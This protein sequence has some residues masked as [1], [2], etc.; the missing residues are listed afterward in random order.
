MSNKDNEYKGSTFWQLILVI[1]G[2]ILAFTLLISLIAKMAGGAAPEA[3]APAAAVAAIEENIKPVAAVEVA[4]ADA[5]PHV[6][7]SGE[8][9]V[10]AVCGMCHGTGLMN[11]PKIGDK[12]AWKPRIAQGYDTLV[13]NAINGIRAMPAKGGN[14]AL[15]DGEIA[16]AVAHMANLGGADFKAPAPKAASEVTPVA[17]AAVAVPAVVDAAPAAVAAVA[18]V[19]STKV[20][21]VEKAAKK[22]EAK[23]AEKVAAVVEAPVVEKA[24]AVEAKAEPVAVAAAPDAAATGKEVYKA[25]CAMCHGTGLMSAP[26]FGDKEQWAPR[27]AQGY[28]MLVNH[29][30]HGIRAMPAKGGNEDWSDKE[31]GNAV[32][33]MANEAGAGF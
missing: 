31:I 30:I 8:E 28:D 11:S 4:A 13:K 21:P 20:M 15:T 14:P 16:N 3:A 10:T 7:K 24:A 25:T 18:A 22:I 1:P 17:D 12:D 23:A 32:K 26:K 27:I 19:A 6:D 2:T 29:A 5:G 9:V 33:Y